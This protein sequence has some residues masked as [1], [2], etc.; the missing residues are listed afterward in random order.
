M[1]R[2]KSCFIL[3]RN[4]VSPHLSDWNNLLITI[5]SFSLFFIDQCDQFLSNTRHHQ[6]TRCTSAAI[7][8]HRVQGVNDKAIDL[9]DLV[10]GEGEGRQ[11]VT[12][13]RDSNSNFTLLL[14]FTLKHMAE[15][16]SLHQQGERN[17]SVAL[18]PSTAAQRKTDWAWKHEY[19]GQK[20]KKGSCW[21]TNK[22]GLP[23]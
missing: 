7:F 21:H 22:D 2:L 16:W 11:H 15:H 14:I 4:S 10:R 3:Q 12:A 23:D 20:E 13:L 17:T 6:D 18:G 9:K 19:H 8:G 1:S 5:S